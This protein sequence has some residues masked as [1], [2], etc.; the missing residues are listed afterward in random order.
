MEKQLIKTLL[1]EKIQINNIRENEKMAEHTTFKI[2]G[3]VDLFISP[4]S[5]QELIHAVQV[6]KAN[7][8]PYYVIG[9][10]S[11]LLV[12]DEG[13]SGVVIQICKNLS[14]I[15]VKNGQITAYAGALL[16]RIAKEAAEHSLSGFEFA[17]GIPGSL[18]GAVTMNAGAYGGEMKDVLVEATFIDEEGNLVTLEKDELH[19]GYRHSIVSEKNY[20]V[21]KATIGL[22]EGNKEAIEE[23]MKDLMGRRKDK[24]PLEYPSAGS[25]F[26]RPQGYFAGKLIMDSGLAGHQIGGARVSEKHCGFVI[27]AGDATCKDVLNLINY[28]QEEVKRQFGVHLEPEVKLLTK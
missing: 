10:G 27:N 3:P 16:S 28:V 14:T 17:H 12:P 4:T 22:K 11:N 23:L 6:C 26:K 15:E 1:A 19:L 5:T 9:N 13:I 18:G 25:T 21:V 24:Q 8:V 2:G 7:N 20:I